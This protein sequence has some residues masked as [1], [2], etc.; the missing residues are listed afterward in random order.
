[1]AQIKSVLVTGAFGF[2]GKFLVRKLMKQ[3]YCV[4]PVASKDIDLVNPKAIDQLLV[5]KADYIFHLAAKVGVPASWDDSAGFYSVNISSTLHVLE[6]AKR[7]GTPVHYVSAYVYGNQEKQPLS[8]DVA[9]LPGNPYALSKCMAEELC[10]F[11]HRLFGLAITISRPFNVYGEGQSRNFFIPFV[12]DQICFKDEV[13]IHHGSPKMDYI[14]IEDVTDALIAIMEKGKNGAVY[15]IGTGVSTSCLG[16]VSLLQG[17]LKTD[18]K[19]NVLNIARLNQILEAR[20]DISKISLETGW[21]PRYTLLE[22]L[23]KALYFLT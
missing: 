9:P 11:Y 20:A 4:I 12:I 13:T 22:G 21:S 6:Y 7:S 8:E 19:V 23:E 14:Y 10:R 3:G 1:M 15:N 5:N 16:V 17:I 2:I 18:K